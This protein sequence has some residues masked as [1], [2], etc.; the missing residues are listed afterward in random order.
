MNDD[1]TPSTD[2]ALFEKRGVGREAM[3]FA[4]LLSQYKSAP[5][6]QKRGREGENG[7]SHCAKMGR[8]DDRSRDRVVYLIHTPKTAGSAIKHAL[9]PAPGCSKS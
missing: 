8:R 6:G 3:H 1:S 9:A 2:L 7:D 5:R 4:S